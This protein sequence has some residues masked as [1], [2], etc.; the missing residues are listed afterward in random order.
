M[1]K[2]DLFKIV[3]SIR[4]YI[5]LEKMSGINEMILPDSGE[6]K[7]PHPDFE[8]LK[9]EVNGCTMC[10]LHKMRKHVVFGTGN[11]KARL[12]FV[13]EAPGMDEDLQGEPFVGKAGQ[14]LTKIIESIGM[15]RRDVYIA[16][17]LKCRPPQNRNPLPTEILICEKY[18][19][20]QIECIK[21]KIICA[22][23]KFAAQTLLRTE[24]PITRL[25]GSFYDYHGTL[26][27]PT[28]HPAY[29]LRNPADKRLVWLDIKKI[30]D[31]LQKV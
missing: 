7:S 19:V 20:R 22:L 23:G 5:E 14:L 17:V 6:D 11:E 24:T 25:R 26:L 29:L 21:P 27:M 4:Q 2:K 13:G 3:N 8:S 9:E 1:H 15:K 18:L 12:M 28:F 16:N 31:E 30:R 10:E